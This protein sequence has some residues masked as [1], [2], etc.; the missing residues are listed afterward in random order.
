MR[1]GKQS[2]LDEGDDGARSI[3][4]LPHLG[5]F[6]MGGL[7]RIPV[8]PSVLRQRRRAAEV[9]LERGIDGDARSAQLHQVMRLP[10]GSIVPGEKGLQ[11]LLRRLLAVKSRI[12]PQGR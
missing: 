9:R 11:R 2:P 4:G 1:F 12:A 10:K 6:G 5:L 3:H 7:S 8:A